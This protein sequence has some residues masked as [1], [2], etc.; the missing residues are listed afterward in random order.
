VYIEI[1]RHP[2]IPTHEPLMQQLLKLA[3]KPIHK[4]SQPTMFTIF[5]LKIKRHE[6]PSCSSTLGDF[7]DKSSAGGAAAMG[8]NEEEAEDFSFISLRSAP[9]NF[10][11]IFLKH[12]QTR[13]KLQ[14][15]A[16][17]T[18]T[19]GKWYFPKF[20][21]ENGNTHDDELRASLMKESRE[22]R[23]KKLRNS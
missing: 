3:Q 2:E 21:V 10:L 17:V 13:R 14:T 23:W 6:T 7:S 1:T 19:L 12:L 9:P 15:S 11:K 8:G 4:S 22:A 16:I 5:I 18:L 20:I